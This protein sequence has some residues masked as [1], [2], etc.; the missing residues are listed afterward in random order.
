[1]RQIVMGISIDTY[2]YGLG[3]WYEFGY[4]FGNEN[5]YGNGCSMVTTCLYIIYPCM[6][7]FDVG[8]RT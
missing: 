7:V 8:A 5:G 2:G 1:M 3:Y 6:L 4:E